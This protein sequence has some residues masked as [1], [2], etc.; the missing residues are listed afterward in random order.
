MSSTPP[1]TPSPPSPRPIPRRESAWGVQEGSPEPKPHRC[2]DR[3][4]DVIQA[5]F[6]G[7]LFKTIPGPFKLFWR[8]MRS[9]PGEEPAEPFYYLEPVPP[10]TEDIKLE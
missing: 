3:A 2:N 6:E 9:K 7:N 4:E 10:K 5:C 1:T 8:C